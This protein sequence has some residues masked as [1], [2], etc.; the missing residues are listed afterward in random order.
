L[1]VSPNRN[2]VL[3][4]SSDG[5]ETVGNLPKLLLLGAALAFIFA[6]VAA[7]VGPLGNLQA[8]GFSR[9]CNNLALLAIGWAVLLKPRAAEG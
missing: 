5:E 9:A 2:L 4:V 1:V 3:V 8:E 7:F 6:V